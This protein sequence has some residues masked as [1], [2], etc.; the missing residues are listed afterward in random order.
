MHSIEHRKTLTLPNSPESAYPIKVF[1][2]QV[3]LTDAVETVS[4]L[5]RRSNRSE[6]I[7]PSEIVDKLALQHGVDALVSLCYADGSCM[8]VLL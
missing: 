1:V 2:Q 4:S 5:M 8:H 7:R 6:R 3:A